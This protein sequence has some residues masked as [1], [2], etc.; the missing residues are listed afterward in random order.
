MV[1]KTDK[2]TIK[3]KKLYCH[4]GRLALVGD[5]VYLPHYYGNITGEYPYKRKIKFITEDYIIFDKKFYIN[6]EGWF[7]QLKIEDAKNLILVNHITFDISES[8]YQMINDGRK[9]A[10][11]TVSGNDFYTGKVLPNEDFDAYVKEGLVKSIA[12]KI[13][14]FSSFGNVL[15]DTIKKEVNL[16]FY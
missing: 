15:I 9:F 14:G 8:S 16:I 2:Y 1:I 5:T 12:E 11:C 7:T 6:D 4:D 3:N 13:E 10:F